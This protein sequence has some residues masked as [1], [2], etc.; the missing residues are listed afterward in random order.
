MGVAVEDALGRS[1][2]R[3]VSKVPA[4]LPARRAP[5]AAATHCNG[6]QAAF[7]GGLKRERI[8][9]VS[10][11]F[12][13]KFYD[14]DEVPRPAAPPGRAC[15]AP[16]RAAAGGVR[17]VGHVRRGQLDVFRVPRPRRRKRRRRRRRPTVVHCA[18]CRQIFTVDEGGDEKQLAQLGE[19]AFF[20]EVGMLLDLPRTATVRTVERWCG[21]VVLPGRWL[22]A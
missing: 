4:F 18:R 6:R 14:A 9:G 1:L 20:G 16:H 22:T 19:G 13:A 10:M 21:V 5:A 11:L 17:G 15:T 7:L 12:R 3:A 2:A 8:A